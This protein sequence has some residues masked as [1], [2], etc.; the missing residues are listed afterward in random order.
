MFTAT[1]RATTAGSGATMNRACRILVVED[2][3]TQALKLRLLL[4]EQ[5]WRVSIASAAEAAMAALGD[6]LPD[7]MLVDY[8]LPGMDGDEFCR[9][10]RMNLH[11]RGIP[12]LMMTSSAP[13][14]AETR[15][16]ESGA[17]DYISK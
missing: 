11:T 12:I 14:T 3:E 15:S 10:V 6:P 1:Y 16:L 4:E 5:G 9:R 7:L 2:S 8:N 13:A 17:D